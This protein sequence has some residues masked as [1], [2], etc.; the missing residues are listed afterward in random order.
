MINSIGIHI[1]VADFK[2]SVSFYQHLGFKKVFEYGPNK[3]VREDYSG[4]VFELN[5]TRLEIA[6]GHRAVAPQVF[7]DKVESA[8]ISLMIGV[9]SLSSL[10]KVCKKNNIKISKQPI[11]YYWGTLEM[12]V[13][14]PDGVVL[15]FICNY[16]KSEAKKIKPREVLAV[17][18]PIQN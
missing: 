1:K 3:S 14:D 4:T 15:V 11:H 18:S 7:K 8:K 12:V 17:Q 6:D 13:K 10:I 9:D 5:G 2:K 16:T